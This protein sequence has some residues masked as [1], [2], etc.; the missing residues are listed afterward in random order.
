MYKVKIALNDLPDELI[1][2]VVEV[3]QFKT[4]DALALRWVSYRPDC[5][6]GSDGLT[7]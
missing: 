4:K 3:G 2:F 5:V 6:Q 7:G 1:I